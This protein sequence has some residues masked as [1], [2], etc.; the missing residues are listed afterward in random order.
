MNAVQQ[1]GWYGDPWN[2]GCYRW[3]D[4]RRWTHHTQQPQPATVTPTGAQPP[5]EEASGLQTVAGLAVIA[6]FCLA[7]FAGCN[8][9]LSSGDTDS[10][11]ATAASTLPGETSDQPTPQL[12]DPATAMGSLVN[13]TFNQMWTSKTPSERT[14][15]CALW[16]A[17]PEKAWNAFDQGQ[18][19]D[20]VI[21]RDDFHTFFARHC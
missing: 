19:P 13:T 11:A 1:P 21:T 6:A 12:T 10:P 15:M 4:G 8:A 5:Q 20:G 7:L 14:Q 9:L 17:M 2:P 3:W 16:M 18:G